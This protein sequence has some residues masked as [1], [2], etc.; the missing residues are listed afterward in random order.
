VLLS[1]AVAAF[2]RAR[3]D[4][5]VEDRDFARLQEIRKRLGMDT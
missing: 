2:R 3:R 5:K 4:M 1:V